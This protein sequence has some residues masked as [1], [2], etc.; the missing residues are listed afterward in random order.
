[1]HQHM[2]AITIKMI[3]IWKFMDKKGWLA[4]ANIY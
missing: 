3:F 4:Q 1:M 2:L